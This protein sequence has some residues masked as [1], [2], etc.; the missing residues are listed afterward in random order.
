MELRMIVITGGGT[1]GHLRVAKA[2]AAELKKRGERLVFVGSQ[3]GADRRWFEGSELF[4]ECEFLP[5]RGVVNKR[6]LAKLT[7]LFEIVKLSF[8]VRKKLRKWGAKAVVS[9]GGY[10][11]AP[12]SFAAIL[13][14]VKLFLHEQNAVTGRLNGLLKP[15]AKGFFSSYSNP[16]YAYPVEEAFFTAARQRV[17]LKQVL[18]LGGSQGAVAINDLFLRLLPEL[19]KRGLRVTC[20]CG[21][22]DFARVKEAADKVAQ[23][24]GKGEFVEVFAFTQDMPLLMRQADLCVSRS[25]ASTTWELVANALPTLFVP[26]PNAA[27]NHQFF[28]AKFLQES[29]LCK[30]VLQKELQNTDVLEML[31][32]YDLSGVSS[33]LL[34][35]KKQEGASKIV[36]EILA[37]IN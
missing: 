10:S 36:D 14:K 13:G 19:L 25:G 3:S 31:L 32:S 27:G 37:K 26:Y 11:A 29:G 16:P 24:A 20:Q 2:L 7:A 17:E 1:G 22:R 5:S 35:T 12:A 6:G 4:E 28:N 15:F 30:I 18:F 21:E 8:E 33:R 23:E 9:V 34:Q